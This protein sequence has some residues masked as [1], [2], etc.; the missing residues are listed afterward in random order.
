MAILKISGGHQLTIDVQKR[1]SIRH[2]KQRSREH[3]ARQDLDILP[4][5]PERQQVRLFLK[6]IAAKPTA[7]QVRCL[8]TFPLTNH[9]PASAV[10]ESRELDLRL[11]CKPLP[12]GQ[13]AS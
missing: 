1:E 8:G 2:Y 12:P 13:P 9:I 7:V 4:N 11:R 10:I 5:I 6:F 3:L